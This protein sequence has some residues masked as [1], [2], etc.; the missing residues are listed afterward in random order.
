MGKGCKE[1]GFNPNWFEQMEQILELHGQLR[2]RWTTSGRKL[3][4]ESGRE[5]ASS[6]VADQRKAM[7]RAKKVYGVMDYIETALS[8]MAE[9]EL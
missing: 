7:D 9:S 1:M 2:Q 6:A 4:S 5:R 8:E 3:R